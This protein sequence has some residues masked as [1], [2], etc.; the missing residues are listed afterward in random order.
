MC[1]TEELT[2]LLVMGRE[3]VRSFL[4]DCTSKVKIYSKNLLAGSRCSRSGCAAPQGVSS[5]GMRALPAA[6][7][8]A[9]GRD[10]EGCAGGSAV[11][12]VHLPTRPASRKFRGPGGLLTGR[13]GSFLG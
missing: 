10:T 6:G 12:S 8:A 13:L 9:G 5:R 2:Y 1:D 11:G 3:V 4:E 7:S